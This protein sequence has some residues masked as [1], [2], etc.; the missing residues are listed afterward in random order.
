MVFFFMLC[1]QVEVL[2]QV[3]EDTS[4]IIQT[5]QE[6]LSRTLHELQLII[7]ERLGLEKDSR[8]T[9]TPVCDMHDAQVECDI[10]T[11]PPEVPEEPID[12]DPKKKGKKK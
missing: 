10:P 5:F 6:E 3:K 2:D 7:S 11:P 9:Q 4:R 1:C 12:E 8:S